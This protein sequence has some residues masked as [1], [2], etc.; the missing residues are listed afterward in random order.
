MRPVFSDS[1]M[2]LGLVSRIQGEELDQ[3]AP[4]APRPA[5]GRTLCQRHRR[6]A[7]RTPSE[8]I[9]PREPPASGGAVE[10]RKQGLL[11]FFRLRPARSPFH[12]KLLDCLGQCL[13]GVPGL[14]A[15]R[16][17]VENPLTTGHDVAIRE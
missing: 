6:D 7:E 2:S 3:A 13:I 12:E 17:R 11:R 14:A 5:G 1:E 8:G 4:D 9:P 10:V 16:K 15:D